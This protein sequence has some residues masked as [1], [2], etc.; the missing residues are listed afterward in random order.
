MSK[1]ILMILL[2]F[3][4]NVGMAEWTKVNL[5]DEM[6]TYVD[7]ATIRKNGYLVKMWTLID[8]KTVQQS[9]SNKFLSMMGQIEYD[10]KEEQFR[11]LE[12]TLFSSNMVE[13]KVLYS[14]NNSNLDWSPVPPGSVAETNFQIACGEKLN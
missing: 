7:L 9:G 8:Y 6:T 5:D 12:T 3:I 10:C 14:R 2:A 11:A 13:G 4:S 1:I